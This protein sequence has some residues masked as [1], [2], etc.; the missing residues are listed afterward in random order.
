MGETVNAQPFKACDRNLG[1]L[2]PHSALFAP[3]QDIARAKSPG[4]CPYR[5]S[6]FG[7]NRNIDIKP[8]ISMF[9]I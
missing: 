7:K 4:R 1:G 3:K 6:D 9:Y 2:G 5:R 8:W